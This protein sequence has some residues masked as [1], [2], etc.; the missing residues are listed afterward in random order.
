MNIISLQKKIFILCWTAYAGGYLC[1]TN[2]SIVIPDLIRELHWEKTFIGLISSL[3]FWAYAFGQLINGY[4][5]DRINPRIFIFISLI[6]SSLVN[7]ILGLISNKF[8]FAVLWGINGFL[9]SMLWG[10]IIRTLGLWFSD[11]DNNKICFGIST[12]MFIGYIVYWGPI[13]RIIR[14]IN[15]RL[16]FLSP[17]ILVFLF[18]FYWLKSIPYKKEEIKEKNLDTEKLSIKELFTPTLFLIATACIVQGIVKESM[19]LWTPIILKETFGESIPLFISFIPFFSLIGL[20]FIGQINQKNKKKEED[21]VRILYLASLITCI[22]LFL[23]LGFNIFLT[24]I[25]LGILSAL[26][27]GINVLL[28]ANIPLRFT[29]YNT[30]STVAG[31]LDFS[32]YIGSALGNIF[33]G[34][35]ASNFGWKRIILLWGIL[36]IVG[37]ISTYLTSKEGF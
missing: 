27:Y 18:S 5:G 15:W 13:G 2:L 24:I 12:S 20:F 8:F 22:F 23:L 10:P 30:T 3:F 26:F 25:L 17:G 35:L 19:G 29:K 7:V 1:R 6:L 28:L 34:I 36:S 4:V 14:D 21:T 9:L 16:I 11:E 32:S 31:F 37:I 33:T